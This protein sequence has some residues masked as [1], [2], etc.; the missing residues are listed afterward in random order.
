MATNKLTDRS[1]KA[2]KSNEKIQKM[3]D[4]GGLQL[5]VM[6]TGAKL[7][8]IAYRYGG[9]QKLMALGKYPDLT[10]NGAREALAEARGS[11]VAG[12]DPSIA[13]KISAANTFDAVANEWLERQAAEG[14]SPVTLKKNT[15]V[16]S[17]ARPAIGPRP[18]AEITSA[19][20]LVILQGLQQKGTLETAH[21]VRAIVGAVF[22]FAIATNRAKA[23]P[24][25]ALAGAITPPR[26]KH[27][28]ALL[29][30]TQFGGLLREIS[31]FEGQASTRVALMLCAILA[32]RPGELRHAEWCEF[33]LDE[34]V[35]AV[36]AG[37]MKMRKPHVVPL[38]K[39][40][41]ALLR[42]LHLLTGKGRL[43]LP[44]IRDAERP[45]SENTLNAALRRL[46]YTKEQASA[47]GFRATFST[48]ANESGLWSPD[49]I[50]RQLAHADPDAVR[51][52]YARG[53]YWD[54][55][56]K[57]AQWWADHC[58]MLKSGA[59]LLP[60]RTRKWL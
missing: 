38:P 19:E 5:W 14:R 28:A 8:R 46:G 51:G 29:D 2:A 20:C 24:T 10:L 36:P 9:K 4:G 31:D 40:A 22:R 45:I 52:A 49:A 7:W 27:R 16:L 48:L 53:A 30:P 55:R 33:N 60:F 54:E 50:E 43:L 1:V 39:Q 58:D 12:V 35:W 44:S 56:V 15:W 41:I 47:H 11:L 18:I 25:V 37:R 59:K 21:R 17:L 3:S 26:V 13:R 23:D 34:A 6:P 57:L 32:P 42:Q